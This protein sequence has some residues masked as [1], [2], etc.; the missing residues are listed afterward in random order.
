MGAG[1]GG[2]GAVELAQVRPGAATDRGRFNACGRVRGAASQG[3][4]VT[5]VASFGACFGDSVDG[6][7]SDCEHD[8]AAD[9]AVEAG[10]GV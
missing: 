2:A 9:E 5:S 6:M 7:F 4:V 10:G 1:A 8:N 3:E